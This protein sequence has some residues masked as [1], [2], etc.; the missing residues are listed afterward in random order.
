MKRK[1]DVPEE[2]FSIATTSQVMLSPL[3]AT[4]TALS[5]RRGTGR[6]TAKILG[7]ADAT[8][9]F[10]KAVEEK[11]AV[12]KTAGKKA[13]VK[14]NAVVTTADWTPLWPA[15]LGTRAHT[16]SIYN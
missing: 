12:K 7:D 14:K 8:A 13:A 16:C 1:G 6:K 11:A 2:F 5:T 15:V 4:G 9:A 10:N 3:S